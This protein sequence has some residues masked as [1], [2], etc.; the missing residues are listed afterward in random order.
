LHRHALPLA[1]ILFGI[2]SLSAVVI[3]AY[4]AGNL[5]GG[6]APARGLVTRVVEI[7]PARNGLA[8]VTVT[9]NKPPTTQDNMAIDQ[10]GRS[11]QLSIDFQLPA[12]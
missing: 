11:A 1:M 8:H 4:N 5:E 12:K 3:Q 6:S 2:I 7:K 9:D 10:A